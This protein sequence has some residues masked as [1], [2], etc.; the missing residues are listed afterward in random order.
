MKY[1]VY[2]FGLLFLLGAMGC[3][4]EGHEHHHEGGAREG[5][6]GGYGHGEYQAYPNDWN[7]P[8]Y[9]H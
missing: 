7:H 5:Y 9:H 4:E 2:L 8:E 1:F 3:E 6:Y